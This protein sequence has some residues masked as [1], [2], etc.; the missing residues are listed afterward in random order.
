MHLRVYMKLLVNSFTLLT[1]NLLSEFRFTVARRC[2]PQ[3]IEAWL[4]VDIFF[5]RTIT[6]PC[7]A[8]CQYGECS[9]VLPP[10]ILVLP[11]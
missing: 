8:V 9:A 10:S 7:C 1:F 11:V 5:V 3:C 6:A 4:P 2:L